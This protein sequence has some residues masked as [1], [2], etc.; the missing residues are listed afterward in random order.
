[1]SMARKM[2]NSCCL[3]YTKHHHEFFFFFSLFLFFNNIRIKFK[4]VLSLEI[5]KNPKCTSLFTILSKSL[6]LMLSI[7]GWEIKSKVTM[8]LFMFLGCD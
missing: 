8:H 6:K 4:I 7:V 1:M 5:K 2:M 3:I